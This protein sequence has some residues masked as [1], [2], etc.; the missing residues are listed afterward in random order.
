MT[1]VRSFIRKGQIRSVRFSADGR[2]LGV[3]LKKGSGHTTGAIVI[4]DIETG[5]ET[6]SVFIFCD[7]LSLNYERQHTG[8]IFT[9]F[10]KKRF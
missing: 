9:I 7:L 1:F 2:Y 8:G 4:F 3:V 6:W 10:L 5:E